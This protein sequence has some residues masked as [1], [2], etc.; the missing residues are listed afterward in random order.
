MKINWLQRL[1]NN[2][3]QSWTEFKRGLGIFCLGVVLIL[4]GA[5]YQALIQIPGL[6]VLA[7]GSLYAIKGY[8]GILAYRMTAGFKPPPSRSE[9]RLDKDHDK[10]T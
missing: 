2:P 5:K 4:L 7:V 9:T 1:A 3:N 10:D 6:L 8:L